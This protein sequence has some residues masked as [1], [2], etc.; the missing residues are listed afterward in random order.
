MEF[1]EFLVVIA[2]VCVNAFF[3]AYEIALA[4]VSIGRLQVLVNEQRSGAAAAVEM[5]GDIEKSLAVVQLGITRVGLIAGATGGASA[6]PD[7]TVTRRVSEEANYIPRS[8]AGLPK[9]L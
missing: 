1:I 5:K 6:W 2:M 8:R 9:C 4:S 7:E 3:A